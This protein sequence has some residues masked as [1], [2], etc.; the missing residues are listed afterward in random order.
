M[1]GGKTG[2]PAITGINRRL[3]A[4]GLI[5]WA[6]SRYAQSTKNTHHSI[7]N[8]RIYGINQTLDE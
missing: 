4:T 7:G 1:L 6:S 3:P 2:L 8:L 5:S